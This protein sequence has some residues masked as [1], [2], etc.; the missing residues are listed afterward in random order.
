MLTITLS[1]NGSIIFNCWVDASFAVYPIMRRNSGGGLS[2]GRGFTIVSSTKK[3][4]NKK[5]S[6][7]TEIVGVDN[8]M[9]AICWT[10]SFIA[11]Q[12]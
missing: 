10:R 2:L 9:P 11:V 8:F 1:D 4:L 3:K 12:S 5:I 7:E 6:T